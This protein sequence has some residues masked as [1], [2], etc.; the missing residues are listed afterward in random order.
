MDPS[1]T[2]P[3]TTEPQA[4]APPTKTSLDIQPMPPGLRSDTTP[5]DPDTAVLTRPP[6]ELAPPALAKIKEIVA[7][8]GITVAWALRLDA[9]WSKDVCGPQHKMEFDAKQPRSDDHA[10]ESGGI[11]LVVLKSIA[12]EI[13]STQAFTARFPAP[14]MLA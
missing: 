14:A 4:L 13:A 3:S 5:P 1:G 6:V 2:A 9:S 12:V 10:F 7:S 11:K 8:S